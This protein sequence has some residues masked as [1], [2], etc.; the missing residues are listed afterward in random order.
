MSDELN[1]ETTNDETQETSQL[2]DSAPQNSD[3]SATGSD[4]S[5]AETDGDEAF[6]PRVYE[7]SFGL[8]PGSLKDVT[9]EE[10]AIG[11]IRQYVDRTLM[12]STFQEG[13]F[14]G[15]AEPPATKAEEKG[16]KKEDLAARVE[17]LEAALENE[18]KAVQAQRIEGIN[19]RVLSKIDSWASPKYGTSKAR[20]YKQ[21]QSVNELRKLAVG[22]TQSLVAM[23][24]PVTD[25][26]VETILERARLFHDDDFKPAVKKSD[27]AAPL[28][29]PGGRKSEK[30][31][32]APANIHE[33]LMRS[34]L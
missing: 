1:D 8:K 9:S 24:E 31:S 30:A 27:G 10:E 16:E 13:G 4:S 25:D 17:R 6:D 11:V 7:Q 19:R 32:K 26:M 15:G 28:G 22:H 2:G 34:P 18:R 23:G 33:A 20:N 5:H 21:L 3:G 29:T 12:A 14:A